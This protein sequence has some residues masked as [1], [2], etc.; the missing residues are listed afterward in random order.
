MRPSLLLLTAI[1]AGAVAV[2]AELGGAS[3]ASTDHPAIAYDT[4]PADDA[5]ARLNSEIQ[6][7]KVQLRFE[8]VEGYL[9]SVLKTLEISVESQMVVFSK[10]SL[11]MHLIN[12][13]N[14][15][16]I[17]FNDQVAVGWVPGEPFI[18]IASQD[19][20]QGVVFY[21]LDQ[22]P[23]ERPSFA[24]RNDC[25]IC[26]ESYSTLGVPGMQ[27][28]SVF[29]AADGRQMRQFGDYTS[30]HRS[31][32]GERWGGWYVTG[33]QLP[34]RHMGN[35][36]VTALDTPLSGSENPAMGSMRIE[37]NPTTYLS[38]YSDIVALMVFDHQVQMMNLITRVGWDVRVGLYEE[39]SRSALLPAPANPHDLTMR[40]LR[41]GSKD[42]VD[43]LLFIDEAPL[44]GK[45][46]GSA[47]FAEKFA[48]LGPRDRRGR[49]LRELDLE[50]R[51]MRY[52]CS[53]MIYSKAFDGLPEQARDAIYQRMWQ[54]L[55]GAEKD[56]KYA[57][58]SVADRQAIVEILR[59]TKPGLPDYFQ[60]VTR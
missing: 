50:N 22:R 35:E 57:R 51:L 10:T 20:Q 2:L 46:E 15:R 48:M 38:P 32:F 53:Y 39:R 54:I 59:D 41:E 6:H 19:P 3:L 7:G 14:P 34:L 49:S 55:S 8:G 56:H 11:Q 37:L 45:I 26:H 29:P 31:P 58:L 60:A 30:D 43:Y 47:G 44:P 27:I 13:H 25:L 40:L 23:I 24:R 21:T 33:K 5:V 4:R 12:P 28:R 52:P 42:L 1:S 18:E 16:T 9:R 36:M 17:F